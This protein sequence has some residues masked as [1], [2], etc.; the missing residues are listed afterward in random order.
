MEIN[1]T[2]GKY[3]KQNIQRMNL[4]YII[5]CLHTFQSFVKL[6]S[7]WLTDVKHFIQ[8]YFHIQNWNEKMLAFDNS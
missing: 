2:I 6:S 4:L 5:I 3:K 1:P 7:E 8:K